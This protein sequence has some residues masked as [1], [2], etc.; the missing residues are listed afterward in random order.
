M[1][2]GERPSLEGTWYSVH[3]AINSPAPVGRIPVMIGG[4]AKKKTLR[5]VAQ[6]ADESNII[7]APTRSPKAR[8]PRRAL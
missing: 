3:D 2:R 1:L 8:G 4:V 6:Y 5:M 7:C